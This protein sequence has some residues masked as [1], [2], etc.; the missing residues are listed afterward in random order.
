M[1]YKNDSAFT[2]LEAAIVLIAFVVVAAVFSYVVLGAGF[3]TT[4]K[5]QETVYKGVEQATSNIQMIGQVYGMSNASS[6][7]SLQGIERIKFTLG[8]APG[9]PSV[10]LTKLVVVYSNETT[11]PILLQHTTGANPGTLVFTTTKAGTAVTTMSGQ[12][13]IDV[14]FLIGSSAATS[15]VNTPGKNTKITIELRPAVGA[16]LPFTRTVPATIQVVNS[17]Y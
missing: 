5:S 16:S 2:G 12:E 14:E 8:L 15:S 4:Q 10:D 1:S 13:Q 6:N 7:S 3:F 9:A 11:S 17:L